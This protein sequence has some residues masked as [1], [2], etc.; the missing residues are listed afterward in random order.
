MPSS[1]LGGKRPGQEKSPYVLTYDR[2]PTETLFPFCCRVT[3]KD[4]DHRKFGNRHLEAIALCYGPQGSVVCLDAKEFFEEGKAKVVT[5]PDVQL[6][7][8]EFPFREKGYAAAD[9]GKFN[10]SFTRHYATRINCQGEEYN[11]HGQPICILCK[12]LK[13]F[14][15]LLLGVHKAYR[16]QIG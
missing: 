7:P 8:N 6:Y 13:C 9:L 11:K 16:K 3:Y 15:V 5:T 10:E 2:E 12:K 4:P 14:V 1:E